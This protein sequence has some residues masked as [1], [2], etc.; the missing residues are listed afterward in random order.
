[1]A[2]RVDNSTAPDV[3]EEVVRRLVADMTPETRAAM[4]RALCQPPT[5]P[6]TGWRDISTAPKDGTE[7]LLLIDGTVTH[8]SF[9][10]YLNCWLTSCE[11][12]KAH[13]EPTAWLPWPAPTQD[14]KE[15]R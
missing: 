13:S 15:G 5:P 4:T 2:R 7:M 11:G 3:R 8:G 1:M 14:T 10:T 6:D 12:F 9:D